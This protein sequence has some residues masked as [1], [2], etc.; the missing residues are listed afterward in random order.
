MIRL[1]RQQARRPGARRHRHIAHRERVV[2]ALQ[3]TDVLESC[4][5]P[6][7]AVIGRPND[8]GSILQP[9]PGAVQ[10]LVSSRRIVH[11]EVNN[12]PRRH[13]CRPFDSERTSLV[14]GITPIARA[15]RSAMAFDRLRD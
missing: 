11:V 13:V 1:E 6:V 4:H 14:H 7:A 10:V 15:S 9:P 12:E 8:V 2:S 3:V 5:D